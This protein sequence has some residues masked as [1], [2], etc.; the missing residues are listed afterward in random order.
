MADV[1]VQ[2][3]SHIF[4]GAPWGPNPPSLADLG[5]RQ[6]VMVGIVICHLSFG[7]HDK[8]EKRYE[9]IDVRIVKHHYY[10]R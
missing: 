4:M 6:A 2:S 3:Q 1:N 8:V 7:F 9:V 5:R 10:R